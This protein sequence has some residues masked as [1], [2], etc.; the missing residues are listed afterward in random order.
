MRLRGGHRRRPPPAR[1]AGRLVAV[2]GAA[3]AE[4]RPTSRTDTAGSIAGDAGSGASSARSA[5]S[6]RRSTRLVADAPAR[7]AIRIATAVTATM[8]VEIALISGVTPN[9]ILP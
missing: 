1:H 3:K 7:Q 5:A 6:W 8:I 9:L 2:C 4:D